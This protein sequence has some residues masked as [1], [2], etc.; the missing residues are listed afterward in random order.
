[1]KSK[2]EVNEEM[3]NIPALTGAALTNGLNLW[4][5]DDDNL[6]GI[7]NDLRGKEKRVSTIWG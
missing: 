5:R 6:P 3:I 2:V 1:L 7:P 4:N